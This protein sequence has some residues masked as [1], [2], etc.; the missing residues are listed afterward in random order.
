MTMTTDTPTTRR[1]VVLGGLIAAGL[2]MAGFVIGRWAIR[3]PSAQAD[4]LDEFPTAADAIRWDNV[5]PLVVNTSVA[6]LRRGEPLEMVELQTTVRAMAQYR[7]HL[8]PSAREEF[9]RRC[10]ARARSL[11]ER[12][13]GGLG[14]C[15]PA[16]TMCEQAWNFSENPALKAAAAGLFYTSLPQ[17][18]NEAKL[19][20]EIFL[21]KIR[22]WGR[23]PEA[24][25]PPGEI[26]LCDWDEYPH[27]LRSPQSAPDRPQG[28]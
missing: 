24:F 25:M 16:M 7:S 3:A 17:E 4:F 11:S 22:P 28:P 26:R 27:L 19:Q 18:P 13:G 20:Y 12:H 21:D 2:L 1:W 14:G 10:M 5:H 8:S 6:S 15:P 9:A 23:H